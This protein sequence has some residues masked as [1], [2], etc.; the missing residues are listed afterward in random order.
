MPIFKGVFTLVLEV[1]FFDYLNVQLLLKQVGLK[2]RIIKGAS[3][4]RL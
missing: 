1:R 2:C 4:I 3:R